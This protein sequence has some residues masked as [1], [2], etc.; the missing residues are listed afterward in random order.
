MLKPEILHPRD[1]DAGAVR[2]WRALAASHAGTTSPLLGPDFAR[3]VGAVRPDAAVAIWRED[4]EPI[5]FL[6]H[7]RRP[8]GL[9]R[10]MGAPLG[11]YH[12]LLADR[13]LDV[14]EALRT[15]N[16]SAFRFTGLLD[17]RG[18]FS[19]AVQQSLDG[20]VIDLGANGDAG[21]YL[22]A[23][24]SESPKR[25]KNYRRLE[26][27]IER[28]VAPL[29]LAAPDRDPASLQRLLD[30]KRDQL[31][32]TGLQDFLAPAWVDRLLRGLFAQPE[33]D[34]QGLMVGLYLG[35]RLIA[36]Q[37][38]VREGSVFH[39]WIAATDPEMAAWSPGQLF[40][41]S[42]IAAM[43]GLGLSVYDLGPGHEH[44]KAPF[45]LS[46]R[47][48]FGGTAVAAGARG[49]RARV[50][51]GAWRLAGA[52]GGPIV[53]QVRRRFETIS[54]LELSLEG[55]VRGLA[56]AVAAKTRRPEA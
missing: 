32:R 30:W 33:G 3:A 28:E 9:A 39:P 49:L 50:G 15:A 41:L 31:A 43:P 44:Y 55:R 47:T 5:A 40:F 53:A 20:F 11:D 52:G 19:G 13:S 14:A 16:L 2:R 35:D 37:F 56:S 24:R 45:A 29:R 1:V 36:G 42:A 26:H 34:L 25:F 51:E 7:L 6:P 21:A 8:G 17:P 46:R 4:G 22:E 18:D 10:P 54:A 48:I 38:G 23:L 12:A 27:K